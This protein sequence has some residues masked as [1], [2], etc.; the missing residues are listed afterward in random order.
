[1]GLAKNKRVC[2]LAEPLADAAESLWEETGE[3]VRA[4]GWV[5][6][7]ARSWKRER[8]VI[9]KAEHGE[10]GANPRFVVTNLEGGAREIYEGTYCP[11]GEMENR[12]K[13]QQLDLFADRT[14]CHRWWPNQLR[15]MMS[16]LAYA[17]VDELRRLALRGTGWARRQ[18][19]TLRLCLLKVGAVVRR[20]TRR[21]V[22]HLSSAYPHR[23]IFELA[24]RRLRAAPACADHGAVPGTLNNGGG[25]GTCA[26][27]ARNRRR[28]APGGE[29]MRPSRHPTPPDI[30]PL[31]FMKY[32]G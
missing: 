4:F 20:N 17:L 18:A 8:Q 15:L 29:D 12:I 19:G 32:P 25:R 14:S 2:A 28:G 13:E 10:K 11:R 3:T 31:P 7:G 6:Y 23:E 1:M 26:R 22:A 27:E 24:H 30:L 16:T 5:T 9:A 21:V